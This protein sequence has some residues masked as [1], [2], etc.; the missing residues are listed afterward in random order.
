MGNI[1]G[2]DDIQIE[3]LKQ[4]IDMLEKENEKLRSGNSPIIRL[5]S[6]EKYVDELLANKDTNV[7][8][9][10]DVVER[11][12]YRNTLLFA[13]ELMEKIFENVE[14][15]VLGQV[16]KVEIQNDTKLNRNQD[17]IIFNM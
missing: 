9:I 11:R 2:K 5:A 16:I 3:I 1:I 8:L 13:V 12:I 10:P 7:S 17:P 15:K 6:I 14:L 4:K